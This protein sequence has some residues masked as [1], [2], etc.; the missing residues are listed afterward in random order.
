GNRFLLSGGL[1]YRNKG[2]FIDLTYVHNMTKDVH[3]AYRLQNAPFS[4]ANIRSTA[5]N[6]ILTV[7]FKI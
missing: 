5:G 1:G 6:A 4:A 7:G 2:M 3:F